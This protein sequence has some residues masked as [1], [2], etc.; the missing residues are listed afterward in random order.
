MRIHFCR[1]SGEADLFL[2]GKGD[3]RKIYD[4]LGAQSPHD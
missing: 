4:K 2:F 3:E 1:R